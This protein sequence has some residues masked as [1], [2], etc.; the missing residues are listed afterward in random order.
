ME[1]KLALK[2]Y[3]ESCAKPYGRHQTTMGHQQ[4][5]NVPDCGGKDT[6]RNVELQFEEICH[7]KIAK[8]ISMN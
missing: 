6:T 4:S 2:S 8:G 3:G 7:N 1:E 5:K